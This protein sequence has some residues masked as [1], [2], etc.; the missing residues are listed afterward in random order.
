[1]DKLSSSALDSL[2]HALDLHEA[3]HAQEAL[4][5]MLLSE[6]AYKLS[7]N[8]AISPIE[9]ARTLAANFPGGLSSITAIQCCRETAMHRL[10]G[11]KLQHA[12]MQAVSSWG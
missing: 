4:N 5:C 12:A 2:L 8:E 6:C 7:P 9:A 3:V 11:Q 10:A 1:M